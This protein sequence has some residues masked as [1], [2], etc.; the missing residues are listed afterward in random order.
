[1]KRRTIEFLERWNALNQA[2]A[3]KQADLDA[4]VRTQAVDSK[5]ARSLLIKLPRERADWYGMSA[6]DY[7]WQTVR[8]MLNDI[9]EVLPC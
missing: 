4:L 7:R 6:L 8:R 5:P 3:P 2:D 1:M 9:V